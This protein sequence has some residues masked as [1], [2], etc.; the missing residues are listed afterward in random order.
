MIRVQVSL[1]PDGCL[2]RFAASGH[3]RAGREG[4]DIICAA[5][6][7]LLRTCARLLSGQPD[8]KVSGNAP[9]PGEM[10]LF[11]HDP[12]GDR[13][14]WIRGIT[15]FLLSGVQDL[16]AEFPEKLEIEINGRI[17]GVD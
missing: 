15:D 8:L 13:L 9:E 10:Q 12:P 11:L 7:A 16:K 3:A 2:K 14:E 1:Y 5:V 4:Q 17:I 6:T